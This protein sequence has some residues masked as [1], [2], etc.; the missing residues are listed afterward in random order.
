MVASA[1]LRLGRIDVLINNPG[2]VTV[3]QAENQPLE[4]FREAIGV[5]YFGM[6]HATPAVLPQMLSR[7]HGRR[8]NPVQASDPICRTQTQT[9]AR[10]SISPRS[11]ARWPCHTC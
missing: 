1:T 6:V 8:L 4:A 9:Q 11:A 2:I 7:A 5:N 10:S 3:G